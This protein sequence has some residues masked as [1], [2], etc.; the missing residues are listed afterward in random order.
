MVI[1]DISVEYVV[2]T[3]GVA[4]QERLVPTGPVVNMN[5]SLRNTREYLT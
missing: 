4:Y 3:S 1:G 5:F 2:I